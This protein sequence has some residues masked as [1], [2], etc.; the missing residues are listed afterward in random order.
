MACGALSPH[1]DR[2][3]PLQPIAPAVL[4]GPSTPAREDA[5]ALLHPLLLRATRFALSRQRDQLRDVGAAELDDLADQAADDALMSILRQLDD[6]RGA[7]RFTTW[8]YKFA[9]HEAGVIG[10]RRAAQEIVERQD[11]AVSAPH[12]PSMQRSSAA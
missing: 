3:S 10:R 8:A 4:R 12:L 11:T 9:V 7:S 1:D 2:M 6:Y 5:L